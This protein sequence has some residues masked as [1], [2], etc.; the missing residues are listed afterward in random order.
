MGIAL[1]QIRPNRAGI[2][3][4]SLSASPTRVVCGCYGSGLVVGVIACGNGVVTK[5]V[6]AVVLLANPTFGQRSKL[7]VSVK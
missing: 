2:F 6:S 3:A 5:G 1:K 4:R 7:A